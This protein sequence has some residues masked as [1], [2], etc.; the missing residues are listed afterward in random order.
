MF[1]AEFMTRI[2][3]S[4]AYF[5]GLA[6]LLIFALT[7]LLSFV[8]SLWRT[9]RDRGR[10]IRAL[11]SEI[12]FNVMDLRNFNKKESSIQKVYDALDADPTGMIPHVTDAK[13][14]HIYKSS[15]TQLAEVDGHLIG[16]IVQYY[17]QLDQIVEMINGLSK[18]S[19]KTISAQ[20]QKNVINRIYAHTRQAE[21]YGTTLM[22]ALER[23]YPL[24]RLASRKSAVG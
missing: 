21:A 13:H 1:E 19:F 5:S 23:R 24:L 20:G 22:S 2:Q 14:T 3:E 9:Y 15:V 6:A 11:Y 17:G 4:P 16:S 10:Y 8:R 7:N 18:A 12:R